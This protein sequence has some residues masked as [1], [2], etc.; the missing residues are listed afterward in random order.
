MYPISLSSFFQ[1]IIYDDRIT[2]THISLYAALFQKWSLSHFEGGISITRSEMMCASKIRAR[3]TYH[4]CM[5]ELCQ[6]GYINYKP[7]YHPLL[8]SIVEFK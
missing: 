1:Q 7:S 8:G 5:K 6:L 2:A 3:A 4:K